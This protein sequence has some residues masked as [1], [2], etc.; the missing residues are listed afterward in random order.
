MMNNF[1]S[2]SDDE[3]EEKGAFKK[4]LR[5]YSDGQIDY[6]VRFDL[7]EYDFTKDEDII[8]IL[9]DPEIGYGPEELNSMKDLISITAVMEKKKYIFVLDL[10]NKFTQERKKILEKYPENLQLGFCLPNWIRYC[11]EIDYSSTANLQNALMDLMIDFAF[12]KSGYTVIRVKDGAFDW[13][14][15]GAM[16]KLEEMIDQAERGEFCEI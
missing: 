16:A 14:A 1:F 15:S 2:M 13:S 12:T 9:S 10:K 11:E 8:E 7:I 6:N 4:I 3:R 5:I